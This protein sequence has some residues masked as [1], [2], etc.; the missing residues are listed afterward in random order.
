MHLVTAHGLDVGSHPCLYLFYYHL[1]LSIFFW[2]ANGWCVASTRIT[3][4]L[5]NRYC[6]TLSLFHGIRRIIAAVA[7]SVDRQVA[8]P[9]KVVAFVRTIRRMI[10]TRSTDQ[11]NRNAGRRVQVHDIVRVS[12]EILR[13]RP[14][15]F[16]PVAV[17]CRKHESLCN[18][19]VFM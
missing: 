9:E 11:Q 4:A 19:Y 7:I 17:H 10:R 6:P 3:K 12:F 5:V 2:Q 1:F 18:M 16:F 8:V 14:R 15:S 13:D